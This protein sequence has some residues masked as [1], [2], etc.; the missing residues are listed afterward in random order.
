MTQ[1]LAVIDRSGPS[2]LALTAV[3]LK[4]RMEH[5]VDVMANVMQSGKD[6]GKIPGTDKPSLF[7]P[8]AEKLLVTFS[9]AAADPLVEDLSTNDEIRYRVRVPIENEH[10]RVLAVG[11]G[12]CSTNEEKY[13]WRRPVCE[14]E[15]EETPPEYRRTKWRRGQGGKAYQEKQIR[16]SPSDLANTV[17]KMAHKRAYVGATLLATAAS[18]V[19]NQ[20]LEDFTK[21][22][23]GA[24]IDAE[25][26]TKGKREV[27]RTE[28]AGKKQAPQ[29]SAPADP[30]LVLTAPAQ[31]NAVR[32]AKDSRGDVFIVTLIDDA[33][34]YRTRN[35]T[36][37]A[38][39]QKF[40]GTDHQV[41]LAYKANEWQGKTFNNIENFATAD[42]G[43]PAP[44]TADEIPFGTPQA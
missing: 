26:E 9:M 13:R 28:G 32:L 22:L 41:R 34:E 40:V 6:Y 24:V 21:E 14:E 15:F 38:E 11:I 29:A 25:V 31:V 7:K 18:S 35:A 3:Q 12:E 39:L 2:A 5:I 16:T 33:K 1:S 17:L 19:F 42:A 36:Q 37:A 10:S 8:G 30:P 44:L 4:A 20:D 43:A 27:K 23:Q